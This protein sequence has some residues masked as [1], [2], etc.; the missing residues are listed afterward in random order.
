MIEDDDLSTA[1]YE[2]NVIDLGQLMQE[3]CYLA[4]P[5]K[6]CARRAAGASARTAARTSIPLRACASGRGGPAAGGARATAQGQV[7]MPNP[8]RRHSKARTRN[9]GPTTRSSPPRWARARTATR[10]GG[11]PDLPAVRL[12]SWPPGARSQGS[13]VP[14]ARGGRRDGRRPRPGR[15]RGGAVA[16]AR[17][18]DVGVTL[19]GPPLRWRGAGAPSG[20][21]PTRPPRRARRRRRG[22]GERPSEALRRRPQSSVRVAADLVARGAADALFSAGNTGATVLAAYTAFG[23]LRGVDRPPS[24]RR[25]H[26]ARDRNPPRHRGHRRLPPPAP[27]GLRRDG[28]RLRPRRPRD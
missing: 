17:Q 8:K 16:A 3:Q 5:M 25:A 9:A 19:V 10:P 20:R 21:G 7:T 12:L 24:R 1:F 4:V 11:A 13:V 18:A 28:S 15:A 27:G 26:E 22:M 23:L 14:D 2:D 6:P